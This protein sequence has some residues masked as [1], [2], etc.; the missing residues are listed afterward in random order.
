MVQKL[1]ATASANSQQRGYEAT[2]A[3]DGDP[4][5]MWHTNWEPSPSPPPH[6]LALDLQK[7]VAL[8]GIRCVPRS[9]KN[10]NGRIGTF[11]VHVSGDGAK[12][13]KV[14]MGKWSNDAIAKIVQFERP[15]TAR[16]VKLTALQEVN[17]NGWSSLAEIDV[18]L[19]EK[20]T[21]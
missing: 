9:D 4:R 12:W 18:I 5:T 15:A 3:I 14:A 16:Y 6:W 7:T 2:R 8:A 21:P 11:E 19:A 13:I 20:A 10:P 17:G 1:G